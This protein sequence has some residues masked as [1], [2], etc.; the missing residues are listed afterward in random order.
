MSN[1][2]ED[3]RAALV[4]RESSGNYSLVNTLG[5]M[6]AYQFGEAA[7]IDLGFVYPD[8]DPY[9]NDFG[10]G[11]TGKLGIDSAAEFLTTPAAQDAAADEWFELV[12][13]YAG[14]LG[15][16]AYL[17]QTVGGVYITAS[18]IIAGA[19]LLG[20]GAV[21]TWLES[22]G[23]AAL[24]DAYGTPLAEYLALFSGYEMPF[25]TGETLEGLVPGDEGLLLVGDASDDILTGADG[26]DTLD[27]GAGSDRLTGDAGDDTLD[28]GAQSD[29]LIGGAGN[30]LLIGGDGIDVLVA[31]AGGDTLFGGEA[32]DLLFGI[33]DRNEMLGEGGNDFLFG[34]S[35]TD[36][37][38]FS[39]DDGN[40]RVFGFDPSS[41]G[42]VV[43]LRAVSAITDYTDL[44]ANHMEQDGDNVVIDDH[45]G[46]T[47]ILVGLSL[48]E[49]ESGDFLL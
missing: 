35:G 18:A 31:G 14:A 26:D 24:Y 3:F 4:F 46:T 44:V 2:Y 42:D 27:G 38:I 45:A 28:G 11:W 22:G 20:A 37:F 19:H 43:D 7:L 10:G 48:N 6:G 39:D 34:G 30:D 15:L 5:F 12:W 33:S 36:L 25:D 9:D 21:E 49:L 40:D 47:I 1:T 41:T 8:G 29:V 17:G 23:T 16:D 13:S 32:T